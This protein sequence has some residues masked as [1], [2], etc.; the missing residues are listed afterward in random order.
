MR[1]V[2]IGSDMREIRRGLPQKVE[3]ERV[4]A[5]PLKVYTLQLR[6]SIMIIVLIFMKP[7]RHLFVQNGN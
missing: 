3:M 6:P 7:M 5:I 1:V 2:N 4:G